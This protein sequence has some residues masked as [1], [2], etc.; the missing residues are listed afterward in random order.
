MLRPTFRFYPVL[1][2]A[3]PV[4]ALAAA[5]PGEY[6]AWDLLTV[7]AVVVGAAAALNLVVALPLRRRWPNNIAPAITL[8]L[9]VW[10]FHFAWLSQLLERI[11]YTLTRPRTLAAMI[12][13]VA[14]AWLIVGRPQLRRFTVFMSLLGAFL[15][16]QLVLAIGVGQLGG[17]RAIR[18][19]TTVSDFA[20]PIQVRSD[21]RHPCAQPKPDIYLL[22]LDGYANAGVLRKIYGFSNERFQDSLRAFGFRIPH[23]VRSNYVHTHLSLA[24]MLNLDYVT[25]LKADLGERATDPSILGYLIENNRAV[26]FLH[27][28]GY[29]FVFSPSSWW[30]AT[31][32]NR[33]A[34]VQLQAWPRFDLTRELGR[35]DLRR[36]LRDQTLVSVFTAPRRD[37]D[38]EDILNAFRAMQDVPAMSQP[39]VL[40]AHVLAPHYPY[41][42]DAN[43]NPRVHRAEHT[44]PHPWEDHQ[45]YLDQLLCVNRLTLK[46]VGDV[47]KRSP[48]LPIIILQGDHGTNTR[49]LANKYSAWTVTA[50][51]AAERFGAFGAYYLPCGQDTAFAGEVTPVNVL[52]KV[53]ST[54]LSADLPTRPDSF[55]FS[56]SKR[57][58]EFVRFAAGPDGSLTGPLPNL[59]LITPAGRPPAATG[60]RSP[61]APP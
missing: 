55:Y 32:Q 47:L 56:V 17:A 18:Q 23:A 52:R 6:A 53:F 37:A 25:R 14:L 54:F 8:L 49:D 2:A 20:K 61:P 48:S 44:D 16:A 39:T 9:I 34:D 29:T 22:V 46:F 13:V 10:F 36:V 7:L 26:R 35:T 24:S 21:Q 51:E 57:P 31:M 1:F 33:H 30:P 12:T 50:D 15:A 42:L 3:H 45:G 59:R 60:P 43:C 40:I 28:Q 58:F 38:A 4:L 19:S 11:G 41:V 27:E 5:N